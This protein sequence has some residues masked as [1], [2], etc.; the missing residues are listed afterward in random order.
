MNSSRNRYVALLRGI[1][2]GKRT[3][4]MDALRKLFEGMGYTG[5][6]T[7]LA[8]G[9]VVFTAGDKDAQALRAA[10]EAQ[11]AR[12][13][14]FAAHILLRSAAQ[15]A[16]LIK[17]APFKAIKAAPGVR[18]HISFFG[19]PVKSK[20]KV[21]Y[22]SPKGDFRILALTKEYLAGVIE[23]KG[24]GTPDYMDFLG[25]HFGEEITTRTWNTVEKIH[26]LLQQDE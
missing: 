14:G 25:E 10:I 15:I 18:T 23:P 19:A 13:F 17:A 22:K 4:K 21:P 8:S 1:N 5:V 9:N 16:A 24:G 2:L 26:G 11:F 20:L 12:S 6:R 3:V 7:L